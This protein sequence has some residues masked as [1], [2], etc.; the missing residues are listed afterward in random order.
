MKPKKITYTIT[1]NIDNYEKTLKGTIGES[2]FKKENDCAFYT[3]EELH[4][5]IEY[6]MNLDT[7]ALIRSL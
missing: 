4:S 5:L 3:D 2:F 7:K 6:C 1:L